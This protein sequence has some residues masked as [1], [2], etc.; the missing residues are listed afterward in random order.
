MHAAERGAFNVLDR[1]ILL[2][3][4]P[5]N[6]PMYALT[7]QTITGCFLKLILALVLMSL[8]VRSSHAVTDPLIGYVDSVPS[9]AEEIST[10]D[11]NGL[12]IRKFR[13]Y[14]RDSRNLIYAILV[15]PENV[16]G[17]LPA[18]M[19]YHAG[20][21]RA[22]TEEAAAKY[23][24]T[25]GF[26]GMAISIPSFCNYCSETIVEGN[27]NNRNEEARLNVEGGPE[28]SALADS[29]IAALEGFNFLA[30]HPNVDSANMG[31][32]GTSW[33]GYTTTMMAGLL[34]NKVKAA[35]SIYGSGYW[36]KGSFWSP[37]LAK[38][39]PE[40]RETWLTYYDAGRRANTITASYYIDA[41]TNDTYFWPEAVQST[42]DVIPSNK[43]HSFN[44]NLN[45]LQANSTSRYQWLAH[46]LQGGELPGF[47]KPT[48]ISA[49]D[50]EGKLDL[51][52]DVQIPAGV[53]ITSANVWYADPDLAVTERRWI[54]LP[55]QKV[56]DCTYAAQ[57]T[58]S[59]VQD[60]VMYFM[61]F[62]D[63]LGNYTSTDMGY[64]DKIVEPVSGK[65]A[66][67]PVTFNSDPGAFYTLET[68]ET[69][70]PGSWV[71]VSTLQA[72]DPTTTI[73]TKKNPG[74][75]RQFWRVR[76]GQ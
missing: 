2:E 46:H 37:Y 12:T 59:L 28:N 30:A 49:L 56:D 18:V 40:N 51:T 9:V 33:G 73:L 7:Q 11:E 62:E 13:Y 63:N 54:S 67:Y 45:H 65:V 61:R 38:L 21:S 8:S 4:K 66:E 17:E 57:L 24:A 39:S 60:K 71:D 25:R 26:I 14:S 43:N 5:K 64:A 55:T 29:M 22:Q 20:G 6:Y 70:Q 50:N 72:E 76:R 1:T 23:F 52:V 27:P 36:D 58:T 48:L 74:T 53:S 31:V 15:T 35:Y 19:F 34:T 16:T 32:T 3:S 69:M 44:P 10:I 47:A 41:P 68:S 75:K 42:L